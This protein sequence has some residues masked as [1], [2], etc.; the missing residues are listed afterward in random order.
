MKK[1]KSK[2]DLSII[3]FLVVI[4]GGILV[5]LILDENWKVSAIIILEI[6]F[7]AYLFYTTFYV[8]DR[9]KLIIKCGFIINT[10]VDILSIRKISETNSIM[11]APAASFDRLEI[12]YNK[13]DTVLISPKNKA[14]F[15]EALK[16]INPQI[17]VKVKNIEQR[18]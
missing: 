3:L 15:I 17:E 2:I 6:A 13:F 16:V 4:L 11:S 14:G 1:F 9:Q 18:I 7:I 10:S 5:K 12:L 8:I